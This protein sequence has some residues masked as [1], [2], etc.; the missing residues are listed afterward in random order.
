MKAARILLF[1]LILSPLASLWAQGNKP[2]ITKWNTAP[3]GD[4]VFVNGT[5]NP[6]RTD[7]THLYF[8]VIG[9]Q[10]T[11]EFCEASKLADGSW[12][13]VNAAPQDMTAENPLY[14]DFGKQGEF[15]VRVTGARLEGFRLD[16]NDNSAGDKGRLQR[17][18]S[19]GDA[20][21]S[22]LKAGFRGARILTQLPL[23]NDPDFPDAVKAPTLAT[24]DLSGLFD[25]CVQLSQGNPAV[26]HLK[27]WDVSGVE[28]FTDLF[29][30]CVGLNADVE[31]WNMGNATSTRQMFKQNEKFTGDLSAWNVS[32]V[33]NAS[34]MFWQCKQFN[35][36]ISGW[37]V[38]SMEDMQVMFSEATSFNCDLSQWRPKSL[39]RAGGILTN[40]AFSTEHWDKMLIAWGK[41]AAMGELSPNV[42]ISAPG[43]T[44]TRAAKLAVAQL[45][46]IGWTVEDDNGLGS[47][48]FTIQFNTH[49]GS[50]VPTRE[51]IKDTNIELT[52]PRYKTTRPG[53]TFVGWYEDA[54]LTK[55]PSG[56]NN[57]LHNFLLHAK[58]TQNPSAQTFTV[59]FD[60]QGGS[61]VPDITVESGVKFAKPAAPTKE[62]AGFEGWCTDAT[63]N[64]PFTG[65][66]SGVT[67]N[68]TLYAK[69]K[70]AKYL[71]QFTKATDCTV[72][73]TRVSDG[74]Q[75]ASGNWYDGGEVEL[76]ATPS[77]GYIVNRLLLNGRPIALGTRFVLGEN[78]DIEASAVKSAFTGTL[79]VRFYADGGTPEPATQTIAQ[80]MVPQGVTAPTKEGFIFDGW[81]TDAQR[82]H[83]YLFAE[84]LYYD[85]RLYA[86]WIPAD[87]GKVN[88]TGVPPAGAT[89][90]VTDAQGATLTLPATLDK[91]ARIVVTVNT[92]SE[93]VIKSLKVGGVAIANGATVA[94]SAD[95]D[96]AVELEAFDAPRTYTLTYE[97]TGGT[98]YVRNMTTGQ[99]N[100]SS[101]ATINE[102]DVLWI[103]GRITGSNTLQSFTVNGVYI[104]RLQQHRVAGNV[105][106]VGIFGPNGTL[107]KCKVTVGT[108]TH[109]ALTVNNGSTPLAAGENTVNEGDALTITATPAQG[110]QIRKITIGEDEYTQAPSLYTV[111]RNVAIGAEFEP[112][113]HTITINTPPAAEGTLTVKNATTSVEL[114]TNDKVE[115]GEK[116][117]LSATALAGYSFKHF[118]VGTTT[119]TDNPATVTVEE[120]L[121]IEAVFAVIPPRRTITITAPSNGTITV[122]NGATEIHT[123]EQVDDGTT[124]TI[125]ATAAPGYKLKKIAVGGQEY[126]TSPQD[127][128]V[129]AD[130]TVSAEFEQLPAAQHTVTVTVPNANE[131]TLTVVRKADNSAVDA[132]HDK[133]D[134]GAVIVITATAKA[135]YRLKQIKVGSE[136]FTTSPQDFTVSADVTVSAEFEA[137]PTPAQ[138]TV[139]VTVPNANEGTLSV[140]RK[141]DNSAVDATHD[142]V[143]NGAV[144]V[145]TAT[146][147]AG[148]RLK[149]IKVGSETFTT[150]PQ[151][152]TVS[153]DVTVSAEF[154]ADPTPAQRTVTVTVPNANEGTLSVVRKADNSAVDATHDKV[155]NGA[156]IVI[157]ATAKAGYRLKQIKVGSETF[158]TSPQDFTVSADVTV[159]AEFE[160]ESVVK[161]T[162]HITTPNPTEGNLEVKL[163]DVTLS[164]GALVDD[165]AELTIIATPSN[166]FKLKS[167]TING[168]I[169]SA[170]NPITYRVAGNVFISA[171]FI[172]AQDIP[173][174]VESLLEVGIAQNPFVELLTL[175]NTQ[176]VVRYT[177][178]NALGAT[179]AAGY[180]SGSS[181]IALGA[182]NW[183]AGLYIVR[184]EG[185]SGI[186]TIRAIK[187]R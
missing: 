98:V 102:G 141:A 49:G 146:A 124:I 177:V 72:G 12:T 11:V 149:Q 42:Y 185:A 179:V 170:T 58:W 10:L 48:G 103:E 125:I 117:T 91:G 120:D 178:V 59:H 121:T 133:V 68:T 77:A 47:Q 87:G 153:A 169:I 94:I 165:G 54:Q 173:N 113:K 55:T 13:K 61:S 182:N 114:H 135:G 33:K 184:L 9:M 116:I 27:D 186:R 6:N 53:Y 18:V 88:L 78:V 60:S 142:K 63:G 28:D 66:E 106:I 136:T 158:T 89:V 148:Y 67:A 110:Y 107:P 44:H 39:L 127:F 84:P 154:E 176:Q 3:I 29:L 51:V 105:H 93:H 161:S 140:V 175:T 150:S 23:D 14:I 52:E 75:L 104:Q 2:F 22:K 163:N 7:N 118:K 108:P 168:D 96:I 174:P 43:R 37:D 41:L 159:S 40:S 45:E 129:S 76:T 38:S 181:T 15:Y 86:A 16:I 36:D 74:T 17:I 97:A 167:I 70:A 81:Y 139:T 95:S 171:Q 138:R 82:T 119:I 24:K 137:D 56:L 126:T 4:E 180:N 109:G 172:A 132:T 25:G 162:V 111:E 101:G 8:P 34:G 100:L 166:G 151:D 50:P 64:T 80:G 143:D 71:V 130:V 90:T 62:G 30:S 187:G 57:V 31:T 147:K 32:K 73:L 21:W 69:W 115:H 92:D 131:G 5:R 122:K 145:I 128:T 79:A 183:A 134:N 1:L 157:T 65:W 20:A 99:D 46:R 156:V 123:G 85:T 155:D 152:F 26:W 35:S 19:W 83:A 164:D 112:I 144:I 160:A